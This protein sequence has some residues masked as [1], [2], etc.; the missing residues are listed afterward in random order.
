[1]PPKPPAKAGEVTII[2]IAALKTSFF[3]TLS[4]GPA[5]ARIVSGYK[6]GAASAPTGSFV[7]GGS[8][9]HRLAGTYQCGH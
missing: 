5:L 8:F 3:M 9:D 2:M 4:L 7:A 1:M 6:H